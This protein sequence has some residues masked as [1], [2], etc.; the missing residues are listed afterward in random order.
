MH[1]EIRQRARR[2]LTAWTALAGLAA[3]AALATPYFLGR[4]YT[5][6]DL[7][8][9]HL[10]VRSFY[11]DCLASG[12]PFDWMPQLFGGF[13]LTGDGQAGVYH[14]GHYL[15]YRFLPLP[16]AFDLELLL[17]Y[18][19]MGLGTWLFL[20]RHL[21]RDA[22]A[23]GALVFTFSGFNL[24]HFVHPNAIAVVAHVPWLLWALDVLFRSPLPAN[25]RWAC[26]AVALLTGSQLLL[27]YPQ[28]VW[29]SLLAEAGYAIVMWWNFTARLR[30]VQFGAFK[31]LGAAVGAVQLFATW[32]YL[33][34]SQRSA[35]PREF[36]EG[37]G[38][39]PLNL[40]QLIGPY[41]FQDR[42]VGGNTHELGI[43]LGAMP[44]L[45][46]VWLAFRWKHLGPSRAVAAVALTGG[47]FFLLLAMGEFAGL[48]RVQAWVPVV[49]KFRLP[50]R[51]AVLVQLA[52]AAAAAVAF[53]DLMRV[54]RIARCTVVNQPGPER[55]VRVLW[56][57]VGCALVLA[58]V[59]GLAWGRE[60]VAPLA[61][62]LAGPA[63]LAVAALLVWMAVRGVR[64]AP[65]AIVLF[66]AADLAVYGGT[67][68]PWPS[69]HTLETALATIPSSAAAGRVVTELPATDR[70]VRY[71]NQ[72][73][74]RGWNQL[75]GYA[76][77]E[78]ARRLDY[79]AVESLRVAGV[80]RVLRTESTA[81][82]AK[83]LPVSSDP[84]W[85][86]VPQ[87]LARARLVGGT[88]VS[89][90]PAADLSR[91][92]VSTTALVDRAMFF[93]P[94]SPGRAVVLEERPGYVRIETET[95]VSRLLVLAERY[96]PGWHATIDGRP[97]EVLRV[98][99]DFQG[100]VVDANVGPPLAAVPGVRHVE[101]R[102]R[103]ASVAVGKWVSLSGAAV[104]VLY[105]FLGTMAPLLRRPESANRGS[106]R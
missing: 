33:H 31:L 29:F 90:D 7:W 104:A 32:D 43:Y 30:L 69:A 50:T 93:P 9:Y 72:G 52:F 39:H 25:R 22:A 88:L 70:A 86:E 67:Y 79:R 47:A 98:N 28:Y 53:A 42:V 20:K 6:D 35:A 85:L 10:P 58:L 77:L 57:I 55:V 66:T 23:V 59:A 89:H 74:L 87:P 101:F 56:R 34:W 92:D 8:A 71:G 13:F 54:A 106:R 61:L 40:V 97:A 65:A 1:D 45:L 80:T 24:L 41:L 46:L 36:F 91:I 4:V 68:A 27:G 60:H 37:G 14:P 103:P 75:D 18:P 21:P 38:L 82:L 44:V 62:R 51:Y 78:P 48:D 11:A 99:G 96:H 12:E 102:F 64:F 15:L 105:V 100:C 73:T 76:G 2:N 63:L 17:S 5:A 3:W 26:A 19:C 81:E 83:L 49:N 16:A 95:D 84:A 94:G